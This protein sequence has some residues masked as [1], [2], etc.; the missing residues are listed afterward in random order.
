MQDVKS[1]GETDRQEDSTTYLIVSALSASPCSSWSLTSDT[2]F[3][4][5]SSVGLP[6]SVGLV[7]RRDELTCMCYVLVYLLAAIYSKF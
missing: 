2:N 4:V 5:A 1:V 6:P 7:G 3:L